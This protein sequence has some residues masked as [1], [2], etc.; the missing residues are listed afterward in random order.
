MNNIQTDRLTDLFDLAGVDHF[1]EDFK[2]LIKKIVTELYYENCSSIHRLRINHIDRAISKYRQANAKRPIWNTKQYFKA[3]I[4][5]A[6]NELSY[7]E[8]EI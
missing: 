4:I 1:N 6:I 5:S 8:L 7:D 3:C 2:T